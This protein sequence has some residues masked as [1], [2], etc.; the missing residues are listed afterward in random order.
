M[1]LA[2]YAGIIE[3]WDMNKKVSLKV[4]GHGFT[5]PPGKWCCRICKR[6]FKLPRIPATCEVLYSVCITC[7]VVSSADAIGRDAKDSR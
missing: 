4:R 5:P 2:N 3:G 1:K 6:E 7:Y